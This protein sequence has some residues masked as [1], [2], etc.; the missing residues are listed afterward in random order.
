[1][2]I[3]VA[4]TALDMEKKAMKRCAWRSP[5]RSW[6]AWIYCG[7]FLASFAGF[8]VFWYTNT[9]R[10]YVMSHLKLRNG[11]QVFEWWKQ[12]PFNFTYNIYVFNYTNVDDFEAGRASKLHV[13]ELGPY[14]YSEMVTRVNVVMHENGTVSYQL[15]KIYHWIG[16]RSEDDVIVVPNVPL[17]FATALVRDLNFAMR[18]SLSTILSTLNEKPF[19]NV[20][21]GGYIWGYD[22]PLFEMAKPFIMFQRD[23]P[24]EKFGLLAMV[25][26]QRISTKEIN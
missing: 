20:T 13:E 14:T 25:R 24:F 3:S 5:H 22:N 26:G 16:G 1:M 10:D 17:M 23:I 2:T 7:V 8:Y 15:R 4:E 18:F 21:V 11:T 6:L 12:A 9:Y 19:V